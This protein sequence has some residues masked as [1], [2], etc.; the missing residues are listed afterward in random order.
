MKSKDLIKYT[1]RTDLIAYEI[2]YAFVVNYRLSSI[3]V[4]ITSHNRLWIIKNDRLQQCIAK[5]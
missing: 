5:L 1:I 3:G 2:S 4:I